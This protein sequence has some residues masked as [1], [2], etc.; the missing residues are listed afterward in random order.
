MGIQDKLLQL[1]T[2]S[3]QPRADGQYSEAEI[4]WE[5]ANP[6]QGVAGLKLRLVVMEEFDTAGEAGTL[7]VIIVHG[8]A[9][10]P[11]TVLVTFAPIAEADL[12]VGK[13]IE[14]PWPFEHLRYTRLKYAVTGG[15]FTA[16]KLDAH[17]LPA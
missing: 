6:D 5:V 8:A 3:V 16:G 10:A 14:Y 12:V 11:T 17:V 4:D 15:P 1:E 13:E 7:S 2:D 9:T